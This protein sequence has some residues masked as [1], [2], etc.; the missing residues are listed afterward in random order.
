MGGGKLM[1]VTKSFKKVVLPEGSI[2][3]IEDN[4]IKS[5]SGKYIKQGSKL[6]DDHGQFYRIDDINGRDIKAFSDVLDEGS[7]SKCVNKLKF[8]LEYNPYAAQKAQV[9][10]KAKLKADLGWN[11]M[12]K[13]SE[14]G[15]L[16]PEF[17]IKYCWNEVRI[18]KTPM[19]RLELWT[20][21]MKD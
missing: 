17:S 3:T 2:L 11:S 7:L 6:I 12:K 14:A 15:Y 20:F 13:L 1:E 9:G 18:P 21:V 4:V 8:C 5:M 19:N 10:I 16:S